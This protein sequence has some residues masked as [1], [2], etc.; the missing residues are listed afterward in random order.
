MSG[1]PE[2]PPAGL[3]ATYEYEGGEDRMS[4]EEILAKYDKTMRFDKS[5]V[6]V[7]SGCAKWL[8]VMNYV[9]PGWGTLWSSC[10]DRR[11]CNWCAAGTG[12][13]QSASVICCCWGWC[14]SCDHGKILYEVA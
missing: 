9:S 12:W 11:G 5:W 7:T 10:F 4:G 3:F 1:Y 13:L 2:A 14:W 6:D 8:C